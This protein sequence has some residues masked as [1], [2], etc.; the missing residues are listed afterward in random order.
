MPIDKPIDIKPMPIEE[1][2]AL[3]EAIKKSVWKAVVTQVSKVDSGGSIIINVD[4]YMD[5]EI[6]YPNIQ[7]NGT[8]DTIVQNIQTKGADLKLQNIQAVQIQVGD[9]VE[10]S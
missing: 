5:K 1:K 8:P 2:I 10:I 3:E 6:K 7:I 9:E 4:Y